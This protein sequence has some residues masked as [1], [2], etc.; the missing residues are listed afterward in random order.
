MIA[1][2]I[3]HGATATT[4]SPH[5]RGAE[6]LRDPRHLEQHPVPGGAAGASEVR[7][8]Q[9]NTGFIAEQ[10]PKG[11][12]TEVPHDE[13]DFLLA[14]AVAAHR[15]CASAPSASAASCRARVS[16]GDGLRRGA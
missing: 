9:F 13:P 3:V 6:R 5:A 8:R 10:Y 2:L 11:F 4:R 1:K 12:S 7:R 16:I 15:A 14:L